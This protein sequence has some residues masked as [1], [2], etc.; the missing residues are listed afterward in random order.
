MRTFGIYENDYYHT[1]SISLEE[2]NFFLYY[3]EGI[4][5]IICHCLGY[6]QIPFLDKI[7]IKRDNKT[8]TIKEYYG[9]TLGSFFHTFICVKVTDYVWKKTKTTWISLPY[10]YLKNL[11]PDEFD[12]DQTN[13]YEDCPK[14]IEMYMNQATI[15]HND[16]LDLIEKM[17][18]PFLYK[19][20]SE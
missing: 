1:A 2:I 11:F 5:Q 18:R 3:L 7:K 8:Y 19:G 15:E 17:N 6:I 13:L 14:E 20:E 16:F 10:F 12:F 4:T 9:N